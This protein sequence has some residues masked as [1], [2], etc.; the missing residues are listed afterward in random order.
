M[1]G[2]YEVTQRQTYDLERTWRRGPLV[3]KTGDVPQIIKPIKYQYHI[4]I[5]RPF[6]YTPTMNFKSLIP[7]LLLALSPFSLVTANSGFGST[8]NS[9]RLYFASSGVVFFANCR[10]PSGVHK[11]GVSIQLDSCF[12]NSNGKLVARQW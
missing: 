7:V 10:Q 2:P 8:C 5:L 11:V 6:S 12:A 4:R 9:I 1:L 3:Y